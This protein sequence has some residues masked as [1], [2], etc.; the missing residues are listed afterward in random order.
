MCFVPLSEWGSINLNDGG[1]GEG[2]GADE[3]VIGR[4]ESDNDDTDFSSDTLR[5]PGEI[6]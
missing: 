1:S 3:F 2:I 5:T 4:M 6:A